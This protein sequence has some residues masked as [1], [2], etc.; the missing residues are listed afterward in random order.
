[1]NNDITTVTVTKAVY[2]IMKDQA[3]LDERSVRVWLQRFI[4][5]SFP[6]LQEHE[7]LPF[8]DDIFN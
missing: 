4:I 5:S 3:K 6:Q 2:E 7:T 1:M 8:D